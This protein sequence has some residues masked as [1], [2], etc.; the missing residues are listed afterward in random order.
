M[1]QRRKRRAQGSPHF[2]V[3]RVASVAAIF[4]LTSCPRIALT[5]SSKRL[6]QPGRLSPDRIVGQRPQP[7]GNQSWS[8]IQI[9]QTPHLLRNLPATGCSDAETSSS[10][11]F[12]SATGRN[13]HP[14]GVSHSP[15]CTPPVYA[16]NNSPSCCSTPA[17]LAH[18]EKPSSTA[19]HTE[20]DTSEACCSQDNPY[21]NGPRLGAIGVIS[22][23]NEITCDARWCPPR[24]LPARCP[25]H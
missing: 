3:S 8:G 18:R 10:T 2:S 19:S 12:L 5:V 16:D 17:K 4:T 9:Q 6:M 22:G 7:G 24:H 25:S 13:S 23:S 21:K 15:I 11:R 20:A 14:A 1:R